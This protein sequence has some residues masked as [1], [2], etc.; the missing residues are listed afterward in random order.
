MRLLLD[1]RALLWWLADAELAREI[2]IKKALGKL[3]AADDND[4][5]I[6]AA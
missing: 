2:S 5:A 3:S 1:T 6:L 4:V